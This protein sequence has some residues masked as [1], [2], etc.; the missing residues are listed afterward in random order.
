VTFTPTDTADY[1]AV[2]QTVQIVVSPA[3]PSVTWTAPAG[4][5]FG[6][7][8]SATQLN[9]SASV[10]G[11]FV[12][13]PGVGTVLTAGN[14]MLSVTFFPND[15]IDY[16]TVTT[17]VSLAVSKATPVVTWNNPS[18]ITF[19][20][21]LSGSQLNARANVLGT[22][23]YSPA[24]GTVLGAGTQTLSTTFTPADT[25]DYNTVTQTVQLT[26]T[27]VT[28]ST[29]IAA[30]FNGTALAAGSTIWFSSVLKAG[31]LGSNPVTVN[32]INQTITFTA[33]GTTY[34]LA[35]PD[36]QVTF[37]PTATQATTAFGPTGYPNQ[38]VTTVPSSLSG[39]QFLSGLG[40]TVP[41]AGLPGG[42]TNVRWQGNMWTTSSV[43]VNWQWAAAEYS[44]FS[45]NYANLGVKPTDANN[46]NPYANSDHAG[47]PENYKT[48]VTGGATGGGGSN[49][50][51]GLS[52]TASVVPPMN[53]ETDGSLQ[54]AGQI[55]YT[56]VQV[57]TAYGI[58]NLSL[59]GTGQTIAV[60]DAYDNPTIYQAVDAFDAQFAPVTSGTP[61][62]QLYGP[63]S[64]FLTVLNQLGQTT[65]L[66]ANDP[67]GPNGNNW[68]M[69][70]ALDVEWAHAVAPGA[71]IVLVEA[72]SQSLADLMTSVAAAA[73]QPGVSVVSMSWGFVE[74][75]DVLAADEATYDRY[76]TTPAGHTGETFVASTGDYGAAVPLYPAMSPNVVAVGGTSLT[77]NTDSSYKSE[78]GWGAYSSSLGM[79][80]GSGGGLSKY[81]TEPAFQQGVQSTGSRTTPDVS[82]L[83]D[84][85]TGAWI[86]DPYNQPATN[87]WEIVGGTSLS[88]PAW[89]GLFALVDQG[90]V[91]AGRA[92]LGTAGPTEA[93]AAL[94]GLSQTDFHAVTSG[95]NG[96][97][98][99]PGYNLVVG[100]GT[101]VADQ[102]V[103]DLVAY[104]GGPASATAV[105]PITSSDL[106]YSGSGSGGSGAALARPAALRVFSALWVSSAAPAL[107]LAASGKATPA[108]VGQPTGAGASVVAGSRGAS[109]TLDGPNLAGAD[110]ADVAPRA[111]SVI[112]PAV[113]RRNGAP[114][115][116]TA[117]PAW[118][119]VLLDPSA[120]IVPAPAPMASPM[121][122][123]MPADG[124]RDVLVGG[125]GDD[126]LVGGEGRDVLVGGFAPTG[127]ETLDR[128]DATA[129]TLDRLMAS[130]WAVTNFGDPD[131]Y[132]IRISQGEDEAGTG[133]D[134]P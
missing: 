95:N 13:G 133:T 98:A 41:S 87:P 28:T 128:P 22:F 18:A 131:D 112:A 49:Y 93:Q 65:P 55:A 123:E 110:L 53:A 101:P 27:P 5:T 45:T 17:S 56:P 80:L 72:N 34:T 62:D 107:D 31:G 44:N 36:A 35:V 24:A 111:A 2:T 81:E 10:P 94:Y 48:N 15:A 11:T 134:A 59:D 61:L 60:V 66:P 100:L 79:F 47:T 42:I 127:P 58:N 64:S 16:N 26:I 113:E 84:P 85:A 130:E 75:Q 88:A 109:L 14:Q 82:L 106:V 74:G 116:A 132:F 105:A 50:T 30:N 118:S 68:E 9:A 104:A 23:A 73:Q 103:P 63:A 52:G 114:A 69:E 3:T 67:S 12:Y 121:R 21:A 8:L 126:L 70:S 89:S 54:S 77:L 90:R 78:V 117:A 86:A 76:L 102:L 6:T 25:T 20:T 46:K 96:Y 97:S 39:N 32:F 40:F 83:A 91:A 38:W 19:G 119:P 125:A 37:S 115:S 122:P 29:A 1:N 99:G 43:V 124:G 92:T 4:I 57:R 7:A 51:G 129:R 108:A 71:R 120:M 33:N